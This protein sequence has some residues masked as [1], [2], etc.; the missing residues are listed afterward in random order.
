MIRV[1]D[2]REAIGDFADL[3][4]SVDAVRLSPRRG[5]KFWQLGWIGLEPTVR[6]IDLTKLTRGRSAVI[7]RGEVKAGSYEAA[8]VKIS[9]IRGALKKNLKAAEVKSRLSPIELNF[10]VPEQGETEIAF[11]LVVLDVSD[12]PPGGYELHLKGYEIYNNGK[13]LD[14]I[15]PG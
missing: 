8:E 1:R 13:L 2:H 4:I 3:E 14:R 11:D 12:H 10:A 15:P 6:K 7:Y 9:G 5:L